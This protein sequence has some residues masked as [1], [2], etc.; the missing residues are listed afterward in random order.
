MRLT[1]SEQQILHDASLRWFG[2]P[3]RPWTLR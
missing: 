2:V 3:P 1:S